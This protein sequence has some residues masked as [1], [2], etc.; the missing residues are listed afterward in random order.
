MN[1]KEYFNKN[2]WSQ[3]E[4]ETLLNAN[5]ASMQELFRLGA[6]ARDHFSGPKVYLRGLIEYSNQCGKDCFYCGI[7]KSN[8]RVQRYQLSEDEVLTAARYALEENY[9]SLVIQSGELESP[10]FTARITRLL[11]AIRAMSGGKLGVTLS[12]GEQ[13]REVYEEWFEAGAHRYLLRIESTNPELFRRIH[14]DNELHRFERRIAALHDL[15]AVGY[16]T[17]TGVMI[18]LPGQTMSDLARDILF[19]KEFDVDMLGMGPYLEHP[20]TPLFAERLQL[21]PLTD[22]FELALKMIAV[23]RLVLKDINIASATALQAIVPDGRERG[24]A[25]GANVIM[26]N[27][28]PQR[29][30][31][32]YFLYENK[33]LFEEGV[34]SHLAELSR[35]L[36]KTGNA[37][38][39]GEWGDSRHFSKRHS[40]K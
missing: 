17:G 26:P 9:A 6:A 8:R 4:I 16:Q 7:R 1:D 10:A 35:N 12:V 34:A 15:K 29:V 38:G 21:L 32:D 28:T 30:R 37:I 22:R 19:F 40:T 24:I 33:P 39:F 2:D 5:G 18:G 11:K 27:L 14:P 25:V 31:S 23:C 13:T 36:A 3:A 20:E